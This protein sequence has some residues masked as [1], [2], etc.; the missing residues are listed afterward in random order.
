MTLGVRDSR[1]IIGR[2][3]LSGDEVHPNNNFTRHQRV[4]R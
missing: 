2:H 1:K 4:P 3:N